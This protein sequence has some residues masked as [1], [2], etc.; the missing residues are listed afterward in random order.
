VVNVKKRKILR[1]TA[2]HDGRLKISVY[3][4]DAVHKRYTTNRFFFGN[5]I[6]V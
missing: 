4:D 3:D 1:G 2:G 5:V 6:M